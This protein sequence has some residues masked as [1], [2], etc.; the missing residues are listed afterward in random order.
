MFHITDRN[1]N[2]NVFSVERN[3]DGSWLNG[4]WAGPTN[5]WNP[6]NQLVFSLRKKVFSLLKGAVFIFWGIQVFFPT[7][8]H[9]ANFIKS[10]CNIF[11]LLIG[12]KSCF[13]HYRNKKLKNI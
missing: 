12:N 1:G 10:F 2:P 9:F 13:P 4:N 11:I 5:Q 8:K 3:D 6:T 7:P